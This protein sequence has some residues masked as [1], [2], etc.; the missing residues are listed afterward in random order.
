M[1]SESDNAA[2][3]ENQEV[4]FKKSFKLFDIILCLNGVKLFRGKLTDIICW[5][6]IILRCMGVVLQ[7]VTSIHAIYVWG[8]GELDSL[9]T[10]GLSTR[11]FYR[12]PVYR[13][14]V[15]STVS[16]STARFIDIQFIDTQFNNDISI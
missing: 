6:I 16:L 9:S 4:A 7:I 14:T 8:D 12:Q 2:F 1:D 10:A 13:Q 11:P 5:F 3:F 15:S